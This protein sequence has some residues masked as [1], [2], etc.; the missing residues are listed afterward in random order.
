M[1]ATKQRQEEEY[2]VV[3]DGNRLLNFLLSSL[4]WA[5]GTADLRMTMCWLRRG[6]CIYERLFGR[7]AAAN[8]HATLFRLRS[9][10]A[11]EYVAFEL[12]SIVCLSSE[13][14]KHKQ[15]EGNEK[16]K[17]SCKTLKCRQ[18][19]KINKNLSIVLI[20]YEKHRANIVRPYFNGHEYFT[21]CQSNLIILFRWRKSNHKSL[22]STISMFLLTVNTAD[23]W[24]GAMDTV[25]SEAFSFL[26][27]L[28]NR[29]SRDRIEKGKMHSSDYY[30]WSHEWAKAIIRDVGNAN[31]ARPHKKQLKHSAEK[32]KW[33]FY[34]VA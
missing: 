8:E 29:K 10:G 27:R 20:Q 14:A 23:Y 21:Q 13:F 28:L 2:C 34:F 6:L 24:L 4:I 32:R 22:K 3:T 25:P 7:E 19:S 9:S 1:R 16:Q 5:C 30:A 18:I 15:V 17:T 11:R 33:L 26:I 31:V 12:T